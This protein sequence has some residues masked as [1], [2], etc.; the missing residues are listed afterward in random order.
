MNTHRT[1]RFSFF[2]ILL[3]ALTLLLSSGPSTAQIA[4]TPN[5][6]NQ[7]F[8][9]IGSGNSLFV[10]SPGAV[11]HTPEG[12]FV[13][14]DGPSQFGEEL[15]ASFSDVEFNTNSVEYVESL[16]IVDFTLT[17]I[18]TGSYQGVAANCAGIAVPGVAVLMVSEDRVVEQWIGY[19]SDVV[20]NQ[21]AAFNSFDPSARPGCSEHVMP[22]DWPPYEPAPSC[23]KV[24]QCES[25][26]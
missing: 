3:A 15:N 22:Q 20:A 9:A 4:P 10:L 19:D 14:W 6:A 18:N 8:G 2:A 21:I 13:G 26:Y 17:A 7:F 11:L 12:E 23:I 1:S 16:L 24:N 5:L 25:A